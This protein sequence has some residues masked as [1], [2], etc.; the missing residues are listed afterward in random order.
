MSKGRLRILY[1]TSDF[2]G[3]GTQRYL[4]SL[5]R[6]LDLARFEITVAC[7]SDEGEL[8]GAM[9]ATGVRIEC[10]QVDRP[11]W[12]PR[13][14]RSIARLA[15]AIRGRFDV[16]HTL[17]GHANVVGLL[18]SFLARHPC[19][20]AS[21]RS[22]HPLSGS[23]R[24]ARPAL[25]A[26]GRWLFRRVARRVVVNNPAIAAALRAEGLSED[27]I[28]LIPNGIDTD[29][30]R[31]AGGAA[32]LRR[33][34][35]LD[36]EGPYVGFVGRMIPD[37]GMGRVL[38]AAEMLA[39]RFPH[40]GVLSAG[41]GPERASYEARAAR[42]PLR[43]RVRF[44]GFREDAERVY[45]LLDVLAFPS[46]YSEG[47]PNVVLEAM[48]CGVP[49][50]VRRML[51]TESMIRHGET[52]VLVDDD[53]PKALARALGSLLEDPGQSRKMG[54]AAREYVRAEHSLPAMLRAIERLY[55]EEARR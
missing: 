40:L 19:V 49:P 15:R 34:E 26:L 8:A 46:T 45:P 20:L 5:A 21:Q 10:F 36:A 41:D 35:G 50:V 30:F 18:A 28:V 6:G 23:F 25:V 47:T 53:S 14:L 38:E 2:R 33:V 12:H 43:H 51:Q 37:K 42:G 16:V 44:L 29:R 7:L 1:C 48:A 13:S 39:S 27:R 9:R 31:P 3:A 32:E 4:L 54:V 55:E 17:I 22:L 24:S 52:G 11:L